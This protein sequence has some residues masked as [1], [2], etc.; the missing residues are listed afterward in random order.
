MTG[1]MNWAVALPEIVL[2]LSAMGI[3]IF[4]VLQK[5]DAAFPC[6][7]LAVGAL[8]LT[9]ALVLSGTAGSGY[10]GLFV[11]DPFADFMKVLV[12]IGAGLSVVLA[13][14]YN[15]HEGISKFEFPVLILLSTVGMMIM[16]STANLM[17]LYLGAR[18]AVAGALRAVRVQPRPISARRNQG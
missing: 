10:R 1:T 14:D 11:V 5:K 2:A 13:L 16:C 17:T 3:L 8:V 6:T 18:T 12:L 9:G 15:V 4:G 7:M